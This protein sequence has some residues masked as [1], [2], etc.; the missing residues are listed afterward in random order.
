M[1]IKK[2][3]FQEYARNKELRRKEKEQEIKSSRYSHHKVFD[4]IDDSSS[5]EVISKKQIVRNITIEKAV[6]SQKKSTLKDAEIKKQLL[7]LEGIQKKLFLALLQKI[8]EIGGYGIDEIS[9]EELMLM[10]NVSYGCM[11]TSIFRLVKKGLIIRHQGKPA[12]GGYYSLG[13]TELVY[14]MSNLIFEEQELCS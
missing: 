12:K 14:E 9:A 6:V 4:R 11:K 13:F 10:A 8:R 2:G 7:N 5:K 1:A 3:L